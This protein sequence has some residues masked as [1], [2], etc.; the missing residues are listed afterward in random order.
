MPR[1]SLTP[2]IGWSLFFATFVLLLG[3]IGAGAMTYEHAYENRIFP[4]VR[5]G[6]IAVGGLTKAE[7]NVRLQ[8]VVDAYLAKGFIF[9]LDGAIVTIDPIVRAPQ[10]PD[11][12]YPLVSVDV[13]A[14]IDNAFAVGRR[15]GVFGSWT[16]RVRTA[17]HRDAAVPLA[18]TVDTE[19]LER[20]L[21]EN[22]RTQLIPMELPHPRPVS[23]VGGVAWVV[24][25]GRPGQ[26]LAPTFTDTVSVRIASLESAPITL[27]T[28]TIAPSYVKAD[29]EAVLP[30]LN[31]AIARAPLTF[32]YG[33]RRWVVDAAGAAQWLTLDGNRQP[34]VA[35][36]EIDEFVDSIAPTVERPEEDA[37]FAIDP[38]T[39]R[40]REFRAPREGLRI[41]RE[42]LVVATSDVLFGNR[43]PAILIPTIVSKPSTDLGATNTFGIRELLGTGKSNFRGSPNNRRFN[44]GIGTTAL[45]GILVAPGGEFSLVAALSPVNAANGYR[46][47]L[48]IK[49]RKTIPEFGGGLCQVATTMFRAALYAG[50]PILER[51]N[52]AYRVPYYEPPAGMDATVYY[53][54]PDL[55]FLNDTG[56]YLLLRTRVEGD[57]LVYEIWGTNDGRTVTMSEPELGNFVSPPPLLAVE[58][59]DL[60]PGE[61]KCTERAHTGADAKFT[62]TVTYADGR[63]EERVFKSH[64]RPWQAVCLV[65]K[66]PEPVPVVPEAP[67]DITAPADGA[68]ITPVTPST[69]IPLAPEA[70]PLSG[71]N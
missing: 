47:E 53:P 42:A 24:T 40:V 8:R 52:H 64:Y 70:L 17:A 59:E 32:S 50:L 6:P 33:E 27:F 16:N 37:R 43:P 58:T 28:E 38:T 1:P 65:G 9:V 20:V 56:V 48:V 57:D 45:N 4:G 30:E 69:A 63:K 55:R 49:G 35:R 44:I 41:N 26:R 31:A 3:A 18:A 25:E 61:R 29:V 14:L 67:V 10:D 22:Y 12:S 2:T 34:I 19:R 68:N 11:I 7:A 5:I 23:S 62:Y 66:K 54:K 71:G 60:K 15:G 51:A 21:A 46:P 39:K 36:A 13:A